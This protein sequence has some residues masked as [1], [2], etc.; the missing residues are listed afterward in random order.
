MK[1]I[2]IIAHFIMTASEK[3]NGRFTEL[4]DIICKKNKNCNVELLTTS[5]SHGT[6]EQ[7]NIAL[8]AKTNSGYKITMINEPGYKKN[9]SL[10]RFHSHYIFSRNVEKYLN[11]RKKPDIIYCAV[12]SLDVAYIAAK[13]AKKND[14]KFIIDI[15]D[16]WPEAFKMVFNVPILSSLMFKPMELKANYI[17]K[18]ADEIIAVS[19]TYMNRGIKV[20]QKVKEGISVFLGT[21]L[22]YFDE[23]T[24]NNKINKPKDEI[25]LSYVGTLSYSY[26]LNLFIDALKIVKE[27]GINNIK[28]I[29]MG[30]GP[31][32]SK[33]ELYAKSSGINVDFKGKLEYSQMAKYLNKSDICVN[34]IVKGSAGSIINKVGDYAAAGIPVVNTQDSLEYRNLV[35]RYK[36]GLNCKTGDVKDLSEKI[37]YL[38]NNN[39]IRLEMGRNN[40]KLAE[41]KFDRKINY[42]KIIEII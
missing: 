7:R 19:E 25:W 34:P 5:F 17:Y 8:D 6:K 31:L 3:G 15:Q 37:I 10:T 11:K 9:I 23:C 27:K 18:N 21:N 12:P 22:E 16:L 38:Y 4:A 41:E 26:D 24:K 40:R 42:S 36:C 14:I 30:D 35:E 1:D 13:Y 33:F 39:S 2:L 20:N 32:K 28:F 29:V